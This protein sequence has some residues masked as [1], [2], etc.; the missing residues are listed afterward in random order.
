[1]EL[2]PEQ[3]ELLRARKIFQRAAAVLV[4]P[5]G[6][7]E[8]L[9]SQL[10]S[11]SQGNQGLQRPWLGFIMEILQSGFS[12]QPLLGW[13]A[14]AGHGCQVVRLTSIRRRGSTVG[15]GLRFPRE[16]NTIPVSL[17]GN[18]K[19]RVTERSRSCWNSGT[20]DWAL[21]QPWGER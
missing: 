3:A 4:T 7:K 14:A 1:V 2:Y 17:S 10:M 16:T 5:K 9:K 13:L 6:V 21:G 8:L 18:E 19:S 15:I 11:L 12:G 20:R